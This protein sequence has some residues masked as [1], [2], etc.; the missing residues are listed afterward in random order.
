MIKEAQVEIEIDTQ[1]IIDYLDYDFYNISW[2]NQEKLLNK[3]KNCVLND[4]YPY[5]MKPVITSD[6][7]ITYL[8]NNPEVF[9]DVEKAI[10][11]ANN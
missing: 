2:Q 5:F 10:K 9:W 7:I 1:D 4:D 8:K 11:E 3:M 6:D